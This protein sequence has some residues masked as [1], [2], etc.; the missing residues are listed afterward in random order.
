MRNVGFANMLAAVVG[1]C[2][3]FVG[4]RYLVFR[5]SGESAL[6]QF[7]KFCVLYAAIAMFHGAF[8]FGWSDLAGWDY[9]LGFIV[10][11]AMQTLFTYIGGRLWVFKPGN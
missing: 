6:A 11:A 4:N 2:V 3:S 1:S 5:A 8:L 9:R 10:G 7:S